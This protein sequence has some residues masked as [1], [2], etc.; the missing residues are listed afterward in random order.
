[1][2]RGPAAVGPGERRQDPHHGGLA[3]SVWSEQATDRSRR[4]SEIDAS[5]GLRLAV[6]LAQPFHTDRQ[7]HPPTPQ[8]QYAVRD[9]AAMLLYAVRSCNLPAASAWV[10]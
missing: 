8:T 3:C 5:E 6:A 9:F 1:G 7:V 2:D 10:G 4:H